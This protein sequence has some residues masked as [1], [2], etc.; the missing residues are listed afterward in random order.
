MPTIPLPTVVKT[1]TSVSNF[2]EWK[3]IV[4]NYHKHISQTSQII[5]NLSTQLLGEYNMSQS[6]DNLSKIA[7]KMFEDIKLQI[8]LIEEE[9]SVTQTHTDRISSTYLTQNLNV[10]LLVTICY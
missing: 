6:I 4:E 10:I 3:S 1:N 7:L 9:F 5:E 2:Y 8:S